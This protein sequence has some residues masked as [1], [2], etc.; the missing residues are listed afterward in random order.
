MSAKTA[1][2]IRSEGTLTYAMMLTPALLLLGV[3]VFTPGV[4]VIYSSF[5]EFGLTSATW[6][7]AGFGNYVRAFADPIFWTALYNNLFIVIGSIILQVGVG[8]LLAAALDRGITVGSTLLRTI[9]F[10]PM[11]ISSVAVGIVWLIVLDPNVGPLNVIVKAFG[12]TPPRLGWLGDPSISIFVVLFISAW[13]YTGFMVVLIL[14]GLQAVPK[15]IYQAAA[16]DGATGLRAFWFITLPSIRNILIVAVLI[17]TVGGF[18]V[19]DL[20]FVTTGGGP[21][22]ATQVMGTYI[23]HQAFNIGNAGYANAISVVLLLIAVILGWLQLKT[24]RRN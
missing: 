17:T 24:S 8:T 20:I 15:E 5:F 7:F 12:M 3:F 4:L 13:Q 9:I 21:A 11:V 6:T 10:A 18:K 1:R 2:S 23:Y 22:N 19:F 14:A 16:L